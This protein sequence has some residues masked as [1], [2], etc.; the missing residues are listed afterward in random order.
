MPLKQIG[1]GC[2]TADE[3]GF[4]FGFLLGHLE[5]L[6][7]HELE[8]SEDKPRTSLVLKRAEKFSDLVDELA[9]LDQTGE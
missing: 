1:K 6:R 5:S 9:A 3:C 8:R 4:T 2:R 7:D